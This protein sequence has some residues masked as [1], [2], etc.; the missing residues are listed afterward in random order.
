MKYYR[1]DISG[2]TASF[3]YPNLISGYQ[4][5]LEVPPLSTVLGLI[6]ATGGKH[7]TYN[8]ENLGYY[9]EFE[10]TGVDL[11]TIYQ[12]DSKGNTTS[13]TAKSNVMRRQFLLN[14]HLIIYTQNEEIANSFQTAVFPILLGR[15]N[16]LATVNNV[17]EVELERTKGVGKL[18]GQLV[19]MFPHQLPG[20]VQALPEYFT[21]SFPRNNLGT[22]PFSVI[23]CKNPVKSDKVEMMYDDSLNLNI[24]IHQ[25]NYSDED[26]VGKV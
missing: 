19:P 5:T 8:N 16:D 13:N 10:A 15:M 26:I 17:S 11:E 22:K 20:Q 1:I 18:G 14:P 24:F 6:N 12:M 23:S 2:W 9:F 25:I 21:N 3:R 4:P 7:R